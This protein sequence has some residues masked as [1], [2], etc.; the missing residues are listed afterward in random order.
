MTNHEKRVREHL[1]RC[2]KLPADR[3]PKRATDPATDP[4]NLPV[5]GVVCMAPYTSSLGGGYYSLPPAELR[6]VY[7]H[8]EVREMRQE[9]RE[10]IA[11]REWNP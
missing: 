8:R 3:N 11:S 7:L 4:A 5:A 9:L 10:F 1:I 2:G 6:I